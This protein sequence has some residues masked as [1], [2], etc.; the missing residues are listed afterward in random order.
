MKPQNEYIVL[1][2]GRKISL[3]EIVRLSSFDIYQTSLHYNICIGL[4]RLRGSDL[5]EQRLLT[6]LYALK[7]HLV[8]SATALSAYVVNANSPVAELCVSSKLLSL[9]SPDIKGGSIIRR[10]HGPEP[11]YL[12][13]SQVVLLLA[14]AVIH[15]L[16]RL[17]PSRTIA[18]DVLVRGW[19]EV[20]SKMY[21]NEMRQGVVLIYPF[22]LNLVRQLKFIVFCSKKNIRY[23]FSGIP[24]S[25]TKIITQLAAGVSTD[26]ILLNAEI[27]ANR[28]HSDELLRRKPTIIFT[29]DE[30]ETG[31][32]LLYEKL[33]TSGVC[34]VNTAHGVGQYCPYICYTEFR[35]I[36]DSQSR[37][38]EERNPLIKYSVMLT[39]KRRIPGMDLYNLSIGKPL[40]FVLVH[41]PFEA[42]ALY[43]EGDA[44]RNLDDALFGASKALSVHYFVKLHPNYGDG[45]FRRNRSDFKGS[46]VYEWKNL[47]LF[48]LIFVTV[49]STV[50]FDVRGLG[51]MLVYDGATFDPSLYFPKP[52][53][54]IDES[55]VSAVLKNL[56]S[57]ESWTHASAV[58]AG[59]AFK[60]HRT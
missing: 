14:K 5:V 7:S 15:R 59:E 29:S 31:A 3:P 34:V 17:I 18:S 49:N 33:V 55:N 57:I 26:K 44:L 50:F 30:F 6:N 42:S 52:Y 27:F 25:I 16:F 20:T 28:K 58:H 4:S 13:K 1:K 43:A 19:V 56:I 48:R 21:E 53:L 40:A 38:Y 41:Q 8:R 47:N 54:S 45:I 2:D 23:Q 39:S 12:N 35:A 46:P 51:P 9:L 22:A 32:F 11:E 60:A 36:S 24:Y 10:W 37:F